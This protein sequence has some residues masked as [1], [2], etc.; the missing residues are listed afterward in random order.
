MPS[1][2]K[3]AGP[4]VVVTT[5]WDDDAASGLDIAHLLGE[6]GLP[7]TF[8]V[9]TGQ[10]GET[11]RFA[12]RDLV[13]LAGDGFE[14]GG[15]TVSHRI[16]TQV[17]AADLK[18]E[19]GD[20]KKTLE[21]ILGREVV[22]FCYPRGRFNAAVVREVE[23]AGYRGARTTRMLCT[24]TA[25]SAM[26]MP[27]TIQAFPHRRSNYVRNAVRLN[28]L[29]ELTKSSLDLMFFQDW[30]HLGKKM[31]DRVLTTGGIWHLY[32]HPW[33]IEKLNLWPQL[34]EMLNYVAHRD[35]VAYLTNAQL[36]FAIDSKAGDTETASLAHTA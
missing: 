32:G 29:A 1:S 35:G 3:N 6:R 13:A 12:R 25:F 27:T 7:G 23:R 21:Q 22:T 8:Y 24:G 33:E 16:L 19:V 14:I 34:K 20:C 18:H 15:H 2:K 30:V 5:S 26:K 4:R 36:L 28:G 17:N 11:S 9:P 10:L 31:F